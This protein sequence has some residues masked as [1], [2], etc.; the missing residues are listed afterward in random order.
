MNEADDALSKLI[1]EAGPPPGPDAATLARLRAHAQAEWRASVARRRRAE[2]TRT[3]AI[4]ASLVL[5]LAIMLPLAL[6]DG[7]PAVPVAHLVPDASGRSDAAIERGSRAA[8]A[9]PADALTTGDVLAAERR[10]V[11]LRL[12]G[13]PAALRIDAGSRLRWRGA[14]EVEL[15]AG[16]MYVDSHDASGAD[17]FTIVVGD[18]R[19]R[20]VGTQYVTV[21][22]GDAARVLVREGRVR[23]DLAGGEAEI[24]RGE[25]AAF[26]TAGGAIRSGAAS[27]T[28]ADWAWAEAL[29]PR[30]LLEGR[31]LRGVLLELARETGRPLRFATTEAEQ[32][33]LETILHGPALDVPPAEA[34]RTLLA[35]SGFI[36]ATDSASEIV[37]ASRP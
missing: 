9:L 21:R 17:A 27:L 24:G 4:A 11:A 12:D 29:A 8:R 35:T 25:A 6:R 30:V 18:A 14:R 26:A 7:T 36:A 3:W 33:A 20:H 19:V 16:R 37:V 5:A 15:L 1:R 2:R 22:E 23:I 31:D 34:L 13:S 32:Q 10:A 28:G